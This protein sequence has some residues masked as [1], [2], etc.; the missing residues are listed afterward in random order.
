[1][2][3]YD[4][5]TEIN[6]PFPIEFIKLDDRFKTLVGFEFEYTGIEPD[7][8]EI[9]LDHILLIMHEI[10]SK[11]KDSRTIM[12]QNCPHIGDYLDNNYRIEVIKDFDK[13]NNHSIYKIKVVEYI[14]MIINCSNRYSLTVFGITIDF[15][16]HQFKQPKIY[17]WPNHLMRYLITLAQKLDVI[18][19]R[20]EPME[21]NHKSTACLKSS[22]IEIN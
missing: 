22:P 3:G 17:E 19:C 5:F 15:N 8:D 2:I 12:R 7:L 21:C 20:Q 10:N 13:E 6:D 9:K 4:E 16:T 1:M 18:I 11:K 14:D